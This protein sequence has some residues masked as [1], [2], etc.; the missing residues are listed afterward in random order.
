VSAPFV[1]Y[2]VDERDAIEGI[3]NIDVILRWSVLF[4]K[5]DGG[6]G[7]RR[8]DGGYATGRMCLVLW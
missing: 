1:E 5:R 7:G 4:D 6:G 8:M 3:L 2:T